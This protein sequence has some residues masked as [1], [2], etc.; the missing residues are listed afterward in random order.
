MSD[1]VVLLST[2]D[3]VGPAGGVTDNSMVL[4]SG[5]SGK[6]VKGNNAV[7]T[8]AGLALLDDV[9]AA[10]QRTTLSL[11]NVN[12]TSDINKPVSTAQ[13]AALNTKLNLSGG[14]MTGAIV[15]TSD[16]LVAGNYGSVLRGY[17]YNHDAGFGILNAAGQWAVRAVPGGGLELTGPTSVI[18]ATS[19]NTGINVNGSVN[20][21]NVLQTSSQ[22]PD[23]AGNVHLWLKNYNGSERGLIYGAGDNTLHIRANSGNG[24]ETVVN[25]ANAWS[26]PS[27]VNISGV[28]TAGSLN[29]NSITA[30]G[31]TAYGGITATGNI[32]TTGG[33]LYVGNIGGAYSTLAADGNVNGSMWGGWL[34]SH[35]PSTYSKLG[36]GQTWQNVTGSRTINTI[37]TN[38]TG[39]PIQLNIVLTTSG[40][41]AF[42]SMLVGGE[43][44]IGYIPNGLATS[45]QVIVPTGATYSVPAAGVLA[46]NTWQELR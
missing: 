36:M 28:L 12:N 44:I 10:A 39:R 25:S 40:F 33:N 26:F 18:G 32:N 6:L 42:I 17:L 4:F 27:T 9:D 34:S 21:G 46:I 41:G 31:V 20:G 3:V 11:N 30:T 13:Q 16:V 19:F 22:T 37:Y 38:N 1:P 23:N 15:S 45:F 14:N 2:G 35:L 7:V 29:T 43:A 5:T 8:A 24:G